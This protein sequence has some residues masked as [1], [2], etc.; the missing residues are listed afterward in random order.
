MSPLA[1][2]IEQE[3][4]TLSE[5]EMVALNGC[6]VAVMQEKADAQGLDLAFKNTVERRVKEI[7]EGKV[8]GIDAFK[9]LDQM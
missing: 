8:E 2:K 4:R 6:L 3:I 5:E 7:D 1:Q 9:A